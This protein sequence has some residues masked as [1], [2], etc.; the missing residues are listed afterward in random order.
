MQR[1]GAAMKEYRRGYV[2]QNYILDKQ[3]RADELAARLEASANRVCDYQDRLLSELHT[4]KPIEYDRLLDAYR[5]EVIRYDRLDRELA[6]LEG[7]RSP[8][9]KELQRKRNQENR[10]K[11]NY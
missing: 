9:S 11:I 3:E 7:P 2:P 5:A 1:G 4:L 10:A 6:E 8:V